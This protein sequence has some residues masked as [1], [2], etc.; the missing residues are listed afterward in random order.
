MISRLMSKST[1]ISAIASAAKKGDSAC[2]S[3][4]VAAGV[5]LAGRAKKLQAKDGCVE[6]Q[7][8]V[9][10]EDAL[11]NVGQLDDQGGPGRWIDEL[12]AGEGGL[13][14]PGVAA[15][16]VREGDG[17]LAGD[18]GHGEVG[19][20]P[21]GDEGLLLGDGEAGGHARACDTAR[22]RS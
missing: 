19:G 12:G 4:N 1:P 7:A 3:K 22:R 5:G 9:S 14:V 8:A 15:G 16:E 2:A 13:G 10:E 17:V 20:A 18:L 21:T 11:K 6:L